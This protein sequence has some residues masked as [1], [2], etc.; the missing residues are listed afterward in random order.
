M[1]NKVFPVSVALLFACLLSCQEIYDDPSINSAASIIVVKGLIT[2]AEGPYSVYV[3]HTISFNEK[4]PTVYS[5]ALGIE[6]AEVIISDDHGNSE[7]LS[8]A[9]KGHYVTSA[10]GIRGT[11][12]NIYTLGI[13]TPDG[14]IYL[15]NPCLLRPAPEITSVYPVKT[16]EYVLVNNIYGNPGLEKKEGVGIYADFEGLSGDDTFYRFGIRIIRE[17]RLVYNMGPTIYCRTINYVND[18]KNLLDTE[19]LSANSITKHNVT[20]FTPDVYPPE[21]RQPGSVSLVLD[22]RIVALD[23]YSLSREIHDYYSAFYN[24]LSAEN[25]IFDPVPTNLNGNIHCVSDPSK[26][27]MGIFEAA[28]K[29]YRNCL[30]RYN[31]GNSYPKFQDVGYIPPDIKMGCQENIKPDFFYIIGY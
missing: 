22:G 24:Q 9:G 5:N 16:E 12:G 1:K 17:T 28:G 26:A 3:S 7:V 27:V 11:A 13:T 15:S 2:D 19:H 25:R 14:N 20:F 18:K 31:E 8:E 29:K 23:I 4:E 30:V 10:G 6:G 21:Y